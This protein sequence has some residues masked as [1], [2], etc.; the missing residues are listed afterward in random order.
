MWES[1]LKQ[2]PT[3]TMTQSLTKRSNPPKQLKMRLGGGHM[4]VTD[5]REEKAKVTHDP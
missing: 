5:S 4:A 1:R 3:A 2:N